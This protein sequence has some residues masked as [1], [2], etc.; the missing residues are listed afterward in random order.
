MMETVWQ[1][2]IHTDV[3]DD[4]NIQLEPVTRMTVATKPKI[5]DHNKHVAIQLFIKVTTIKELLYGQYKMLYNNS[6][7]RMLLNRNL[8][9]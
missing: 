2:Y 8:N 3:D 7:T 6:P 1:I 4:I 9:D 5:V